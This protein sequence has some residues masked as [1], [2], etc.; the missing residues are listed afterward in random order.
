MMIPILIQMKWYNISLWKAPLFTVI[1]TVSGILTTRMWYFAESGDVDGISYFGAVFLVPIIFI[2]VAR[3]FRIP[4]KFTMDFCAPAGC[5][6]LIIMKVQCLL[7][8]CCGGRLLCTIADGTEIR[9]PSQIVEL[10]NA[11]VIAVLLMMLSKYKGRR[12]TIYFWY[13]VMYGATRFLLN[14]FRETESVFLF[15]GFGSI[16][17]LL[18]LTIGTFGLIHGNESLRNNLK[19]KIRSIVGE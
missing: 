9:F 10:F 8:G 19:T 11:F 12:G 18:S 4:Y 1:I 15:M 16:W 3:I 5:V 13:M 2:A 17:G 7:T 14:F 6:V